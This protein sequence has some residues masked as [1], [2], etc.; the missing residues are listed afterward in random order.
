MKEM[1][2]IVG[3]ILLIIAISWGT[4]SCKR[5]INYK[6]GYESMVQEQIQKEL[7]PL[8]ARLDA[9]EKRK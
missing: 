1:F 4:W 2:G 7:K 5:R 9:L 3:V 6:L 8:N